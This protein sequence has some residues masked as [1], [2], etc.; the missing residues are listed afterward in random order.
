MYTDL[1]DPILFNAL[2]TPTA[3]VFADL[4]QCY[5]RRVG[6]RE[7]RLWE[8]SGI[9][10]DCRGG[11]RKCI[12]KYRILEIYVFLLPGNPFSQRFTQAVEAYRDSG[13]ARCP[14]YPH[15][16]PTPRAPAWRYIQSRGERNPNAKVARLSLPNAPRIHF[17][18][19]F[20]TI[21]GPLHAG[22]L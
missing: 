2:P 12:K 15:H 19:N 16:L 10:K 7:S 9:C 5:C 21:D 18:V 6:K 14:N 13:E 8:R 3:A 11:G 4:V 22:G 20:E 17:S 1:E